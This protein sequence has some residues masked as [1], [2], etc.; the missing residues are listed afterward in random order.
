MR[1]LLGIRNVPPTE[2]LAETKVES[3][4]GFDNRN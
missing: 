3:P 1:Y 2:E 4:G